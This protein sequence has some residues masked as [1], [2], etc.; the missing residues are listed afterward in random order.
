MKRKRFARVEYTA[1]L[2][3]LVISRFIAKV[4]SIKSI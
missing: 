3:S 2:G 4:S 1:L